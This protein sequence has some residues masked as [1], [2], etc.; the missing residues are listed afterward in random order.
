MAPLQAFTS[1]PCRSRL[2]EITSIQTVRLPLIKCF[3]SFA[4][5]VR[6]KQEP[7]GRTHPLPH[8]AA[9]FSTPLSLHLHLA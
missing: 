5:K 9:P 6:N 4:D 3:L 8:V 2:T 7:I 1:T